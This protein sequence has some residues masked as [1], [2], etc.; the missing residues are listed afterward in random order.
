MSKPRYAVRDENGTAGGGHVV[1]HKAARNWFRE[2]PGHT[3]ARD[4]RSL[5]PAEDVDMS[6]QSLT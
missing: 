3:S 5:V 6:Y 2:E 4:P 1:S